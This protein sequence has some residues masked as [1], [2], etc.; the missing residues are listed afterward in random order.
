MLAWQAFDHYALSPVQGCLLWFSSN[1]NLAKCQNWLFL[2]TRGCVLSAIPSN[3]KTSLIC[4]ALSIYHRKVVCFSCSQRN[5]LCCALYN[6]DLQII[7]CLVS[8]IAS[9]VSELFQL[10]NFFVII[11]FIFEKPHLPKTIRTRNQ[12]PCNDFLQ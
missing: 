12:D 11:N 6:Q 8:T 10:G 9:L 3:T 7:A 1:L 4:E 5:D 2:L